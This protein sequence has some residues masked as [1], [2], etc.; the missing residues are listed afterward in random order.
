MQIWPEIHED[1]RGAFG[2]LFNAAS[3]LEAG[4]GIRLV[5]VNQSISRRG[6]LRGLHFQ[7]LHSQGKLLKVIYGASYHVAVDLRASSPS[8]GKWE[9][10]CLSAAARNEL[11]I[12]AGFAHGFL[13][14]EEASILI[15]GCTE[16]YHPEDEEGIRWNDPRLGVS[17]PESPSLI[18]SDRDKAWPA[19]DPER[20]YFTFR[21]APS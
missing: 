11:W 8:L 14:L 12:P 1:D 5:Q 21:E 16:L 18:I 9:G 20:P 10:L 15:Y 3:F 17:W 6:V 7:R 2:E 4:V 19:F 13:A